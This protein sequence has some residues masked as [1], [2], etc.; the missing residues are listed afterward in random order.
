MLAGWAAGAKFR[1]ACI[2]AGLTDGQ[3][4]ALREDPDWQEAFGQAHSAFV[5]G[6]LVSIKDAGKDDWKATAWMLE[7]I[8]PERFG[9]RDSV[10][11]DHR[12][13]VLPWQS[14]VTGEVLEVRDA[15]AGTP[16][17]AEGQPGHLGEGAQ[18]DAGGP[19]AGL[20]DGGVVGVA[21]AVRPADAVVGAGRVGN[22]VPPGAAAGVSVPASE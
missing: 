4:R 13:T 7:R 20:G 19:A 21:G 14:V 2:A 12:V 9:R 3:A 17:L 11:V 5:T 18:G 10:Q 15:G 1:E 22:D 16:A 6:A 8:K